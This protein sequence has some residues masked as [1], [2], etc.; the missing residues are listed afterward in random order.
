M[1]D[2]IEMCDTLTDVMVKMSEGNPGALR[3]LCEAAKDN[4]A[5]DPDAAMAGLNGILALDSL[6]LYGSDI[7]VLYKDICGEDL[8]RMI[9][10]LRGWQLGFIAP[11]DITTA[12]RLRQRGE[13]V[14][15]S[16]DVD[17]V[18]AQ[19]RKRLPNFRQDKEAKSESG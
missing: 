14:P 8:T 18:M 12:V 9:G 3:V 17:A 5:I 19:V 10:L 4:A 16:L 2:R 15:N 7:W 6:H 1:S 11:G 13:P